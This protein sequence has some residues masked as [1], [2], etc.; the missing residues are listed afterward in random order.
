MDPGTPVEP[1]ELAGLEARFRGARPTEQ[2]RTLEELAQELGLQREAGGDPP[3]T[4]RPGE[5]EG[6]PWLRA[7]Q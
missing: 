4:Y 3:N 6:A 2:A 7:P 1:S 5:T